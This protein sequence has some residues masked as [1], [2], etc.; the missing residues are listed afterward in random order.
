MTFWGQIWG[1]CDESSPYAVYAKRCSMSQSIFWGGNSKIPVL[2]FEKLQ[3][4]AHFSDFRGPVAPKRCPLARKCPVRTLT[5]WAQYIV[6][7]CFGVQ[8][9]KDKN[10]F[11]KI[12][13]IYFCPHSGVFTP[14]DPQSS[15]D[16]RPHGV[17]A[18]C[19]RQPPSG[20]RGRDIS[21]RTKPSYPPRSYC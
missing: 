21:I 15:P 4:S 13:K 12:S 2:G 17:R 5:V 19:K 10:F 8:K 1:R 16:L 7:W 9:S 6:W 18:W 11:S 3:K 14:T 20:H